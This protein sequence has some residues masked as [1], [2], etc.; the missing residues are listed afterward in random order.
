MDTR[1]CAPP[2][3][4]PL[5]TDEAPARYSFKQWRE[6]RERKRTDW[7]R[8]N[9]RTVQPKPSDTRANAAPKQTPSAAAVEAK[10]PFDFDPYGWAFLFWVTGLV[11]WFRHTELFTHWVVFA[12]VV[13][14]IAPAKYLIRTLLLIGAA[15]WLLHK[16][17]V[18]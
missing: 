7:E 15:W 12:A 3:P 1:Y 5:L 17:Q 4:S 11:V 10:P 14:L 2:A 18:L 9:V 16:Y 8:E 6:Q 13:F